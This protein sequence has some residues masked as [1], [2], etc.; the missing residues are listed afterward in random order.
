MSRKTTDTLMA[1]CLALFLFAASRS[2]HAL[3][4]CYNGDVSPPVQME[5]FNGKFFYY[6]LDQGTVQNPGPSLLPP[7]GAQFYCYANG[8]ELAYI[9]QKLP[10]VRQRVGASVGPTKGSTI[11]FWTGDE[12]RWIWNNL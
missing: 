7:F 11:V 8:G 12:A 3:L 5:W 9:M 10:D 2:A 1:V 6:G 4:Y